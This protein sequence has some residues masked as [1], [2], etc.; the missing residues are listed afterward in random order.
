MLCTERAR[1]ERG[2][3]TEMGGVRGETEKK[4]VQLQAYK[5]GLHLTC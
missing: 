4:V 2:S 5:Q 1:V 3:I